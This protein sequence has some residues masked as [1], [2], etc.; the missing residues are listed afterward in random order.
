MSGVVHQRRVCRHW[1]WYSKDRN[2]R[3][4]QMQKSADWMRKRREW[5]HRLQKMRALVKWRTSARCLA[6]T[7]LA[8]LRRFMAW[9][10]NLGLMRAWRTW[11]DYYLALKAEQRKLRMAVEFWGKREE[12]WSVLRWREKSDYLMQLDRKVAR[13]S[14][15]WQEYLANTE[16]S[17]NNMLGDNFKAWRKLYFYKRFV[18]WRRSHRNTKP[19][20]S[21]NRPFTVGAWEDF[22]NP[23]SPGKSR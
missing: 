18:L 15:R 8:I 23:S 7:E 2:A 4:I 16:W 3:R 14:L 13:A 17:S 10:T 5:M 12:Q 19:L 9:W 6:E 21:P 20:K 1:L 11:H 22:R